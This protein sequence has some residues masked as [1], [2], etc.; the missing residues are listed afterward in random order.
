MSALLRRAVWNLRLGLHGRFHTSVA[1]RPT[2]DT[3]LYG[4][5][6]L[7]TPKGF[8]RFVDDAI[9]R[10]VRLLIPQ[11]YADTHIQTDCLY[12]IAVSLLVPLVL[13]SVF[14]YYREFVEEANKAS[15]RMN[16]YLHHLNTNYSLYNAVIRAGKDG[17]MLTEEAQ[18]AAHCLRVDLEKGGIHLSEEKRDR[19]NQL[20]MDIAR[21]NTEFG[22]NIASDP[23]HV[24]V[25]PASR[26]P[27]QLHHL[28]KA[29]YRDKF[30][31]ASGNTK[32]KGASGNTKEKGFQIVTD[33]TTLTS[34]LQYS[35]DA[36]VRK[37]AYVRGNSVPHANLGI[38]EYDS[39]AEYALHSSMASS[40][41]VVLS[42]LL[43]MSKMVRPMADEEFKA[44]SDFKREK[45]G[46]V[47][48]D[49]EPWDEAYFTGLMKSSA[50][51]L[52]VSVVASYFPL[53][54]CI[55]GLKLLAQSLFGVT[56]RSIPLAPGESWHPDV[57]KFSLYN[58][59][60]GKYPGCAHFAIKG[61][62]RISELEYQLPV[63]ALVCNFRGSHNSR[64]V[65][66]YHSEVETLFHEFG[67]ALH[68]LLSRTDYQHFSGTR[69]LL[70][71]AE[72]PS[73]LF[74]CCLVQIGDEFIALPAGP[75]F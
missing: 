46:H 45:C 44:I 66:L 71:F 42:F 31:G 33:P 49:L 69:V 27:K 61:G 21:L 41:K 29:I 12:S 20:S 13:M 43:E 6:H 30:L 1:P 48:G 53:S 22:E 68:S 8:Q 74:E 17:N 72:T 4:F 57:M 16:Q 62:R 36:E 73:N 58:P 28:V 5:P 37:M 3:G 24:D 59:D 64:H 32:E 63:V 7:K 55:E 75:K 15:M 54:R 2:N 18:R 23:G 52:D 35:A 10:Y 9:E 47:Y 25:F 19:V 34:I 38:I 56:F 67:H 14:L 60:E 65:K 70:D 26:I 51:N 50:F 39:Y 40:P 11:S